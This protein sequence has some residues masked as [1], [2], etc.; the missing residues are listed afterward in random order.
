MSS[1]LATLASVGS[2]SERTMLRSGIAWHIAASALDL[3][4][5]VAVV[6]LII[7][8][9]GQLEKAATPT[10]AIAFFLVLA[11]AM[12]ARLWLLQFANGQCYRAG[13]QI[14]MSVRQ[15]IMEQ[16]QRVPIDVVPKQGA[17][18][19]AM[20]MTNQV[21]RVEHM[22]ANT[23]GSFIS[24]AVKLFLALCLLVW[25]EPFLAVLFIAT[26]AATA[27]L[28]GFV[29]QRMREL[30]D[31]RASTLRHAN[32]KL[33]DNLHGLP[34]LRSFGQ[35]RGRISSVFDATVIKIA[36]T[37]KSAMRRIA[38]LVF[39][40]F[41]ISDLGLMVV[42][43]AVGIVSFSGF[44]LPSVQDDAVLYAAFLIAMLS[45]VN[46]VVHLQKTLVHLRAGFQ[47]WTDVTRFLELKPI[48]VDQSSE[49]AISGKAGGYAIA[50]KNVSFTYPGTSTAAL[51]NVSISIPERSFYAIV[52]ASGAGKTT[53]VQLLARF[54]DTTSGN[55]TIGGVD[56]R[57]MSPE[58]IAR[59]ISFVL[60]DM[61]LFD[62]S[63]KANISL[64]K[65]SAAR[66]EIEHA[67]RLAGAHS[68]I[69]RL[70]QGYETLV[71]D[72]GSMMSGGERARVAIARAV[73]KNA[74][75]L[76]LDEATAALDRLAEQ[77]LLR[78]VCDLKKQ[79]TVLL[80]THRLS[81]AR[82]ADRILVLDDGCLVG[83][84]THEELLAHHGRYRRMWE[85]HQLSL[86]WSVGAVGQEH[87]GHY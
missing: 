52:G 79:C 10:I 3:V 86:S 55:V 29:L 61:I 15:R 32:A 78:T 69:E 71:G 75:I 14:G 27:G 87:Q 16:L 70:P 64:G 45:A 56:I 47:A 77:S 57:A 36:D 53:F 1:A 72:A 8:T 19:L 65:P 82:A 62:D 76:V 34:A 68:F 50:F 59:K 24:S 35:E 63:I 21:N 23:V 30:V 85:K 28:F 84:G 31:G 17:G 73:V 51:D 80:I 44:V 7:F 40:G 26:L 20:L 38:P 25:L 49:N 22:L 43:V 37:Y 4:P 13:F 83:T 41:L 12:I 48:E 66:E 6:A 2:P 67:A 5:L 46:P 33:A 42:V 58:K 39:L 11:T 54:F 74:D 81:M 18:S 9:G 60:Q